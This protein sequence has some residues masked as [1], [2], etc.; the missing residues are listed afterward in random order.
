MVP[1]KSPGVNLKTVFLCKKSKSGKKILA[2][3][4]RQEDPPFFDT[5]AY[6]NRSV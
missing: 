5:S 6:D 3:L 2:V 1:Q 4:I